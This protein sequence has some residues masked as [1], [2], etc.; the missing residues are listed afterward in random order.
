MAPKA[1]KRTGLVAGATAGAIGSRVRDRAC[2]G[3]RACATATIPMPASRWSPCST[4][5][6]SST[7][8]TAAPSTPFPGVRDRSSCSATASRSRRACGRSSSSRSRPP[9][10]AAVAFD[11]RGHGESRGGRHRPLARQP[12]RR[13]AH[14][15]RSARPARRRSRRPL[16]G[17]DG[18]AGVRHPPSRTSSRNACAGL[19]LLSTSSHNLVSDAQARAR[20]GGAGGQRRTRRRHVHAAAQPRTPAGAHRLR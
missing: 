1:L 9:G 7:A 13:P 17:R 8:T 19:V 5:R 3:R 6:A 20:S 12:R 11:S 2:A 14:G 16:D 15:A 4:R 10:S 18:G